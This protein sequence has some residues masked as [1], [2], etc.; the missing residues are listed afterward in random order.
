VPGMLQPDFT[1]TS[2]TA[3]PLTML[4][5]AAVV[6]STVASADC[7]AYAALLNYVAGPGQ[8]PGVALGD[9]PPGYAPLPTALEKQTSSAAS[10][11]TAAC[12]HRAGP[13][14]NPGRGPHPG[15]GT[16]PSGIGSPSDIGGT[17]NPT[18]TSGTPATA[19][20]TGKTGSS[21]GVQGGAPIPT[22]GPAAIQPLQLTGGTTPANPQAWGYG[23]PVG[24]ATGF[25]ATMAAPLLSRRRARWLFRTLRLA[26]FPQLSQLPGSP[27]LLRPP[28]LPRQWGFWRRSP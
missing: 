3:Y 27:R 20:T 12:A 28:R 13:G 23:L 19:G 26:Q 16:N 5:Y 22:G 2:S 7:T 1:S 24:A 18:G 11:L 6:P 8:V 25:L 15:H 14:G 10:T 4:T 9:L 21:T 17:G